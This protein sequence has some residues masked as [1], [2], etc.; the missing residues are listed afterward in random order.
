MSK[1][2]AVLVRVQRRPI[3]AKLIVQDET[4]YVVEVTC[5]GGFKYALGCKTKGGLNW[6]ISPMTKTELWEEMKKT[7][8]IT[9][10]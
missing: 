2:P 4:F 5:K 6:L 3:L 7:W 10:K 9:V 8:E 1:I